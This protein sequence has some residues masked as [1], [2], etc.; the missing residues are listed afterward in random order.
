MFQKNTQTFKASYITTVYSNTE[1]F[2][3]LFTV[4]IKSFKHYLKLKQ[5]NYQLYKNVC[6]FSES[7]AVWIFTAPVD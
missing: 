2:L 6:L 4:T 3:I 5:A 7:L 1:K